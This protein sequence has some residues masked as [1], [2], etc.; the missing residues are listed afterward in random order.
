MT[1]AISLK[2]NDGL[3][4]AADSATTLVSQDGGLPGA[5][6]TPVVNVYNNAN[7]I[8]NLVKGLPI[9]AVTW[10][11]G[12][13]GIASI[14]TLMKDLRVLLSDPAD[15]EWGLN[16]SSY[17][18]RD[19]AEKVRKFIYEDR[20]ID[21]FRAWESKPGLGFIVAGYSSGEGVA[22]EYQIN[23]DGGECGE[24]VLVRPKEE[25]G[26]TW[27]G[28]IEAIS[29]LLLGYS[30]FLPSVLQ[31]HLG[32]PAE[33]IPP[34][35]HL[36]RTA[37]NLPLVI[38]PMPLQDAIDLA[39]FLV[40]L[41]IQFSRFIPGAPTVGGPIEVAAI[42]KHEGFRWIQRKYYYN[43]ELNP[44]EGTWTSLRPSPLG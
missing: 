31:Q 22:E 24:P 6:P 5:G 2:V 43:R 33:Q 23:I 27:N 4:L 17:S 20:Y 29:R 25:S 19:V 30:S 28:Q 7:K 10:G 26:A 12:S 16:K 36:I 35:M 9:G 1:I 8:F 37:L 15:Q 13:I 41:T 3:V 39:E 32:V 21:T 40:D 44:E 38:P 11:V 34:A 42:S 14:S 18:V